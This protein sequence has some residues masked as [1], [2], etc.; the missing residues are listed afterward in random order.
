LQAADAAPVAM[1][2]TE[3]ANKVRA[4]EGATSER[5]LPAPNA[6]WASEGATLVAP[7]TE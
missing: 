5:W 1:W 4:S 3:G 6:D 7:D 2:A